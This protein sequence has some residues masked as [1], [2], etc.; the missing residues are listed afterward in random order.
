MRQARPVRETERAEL[1]EALLSC[2]VLLEVVGLF[3][4]WAVLTW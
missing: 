2:L 4:L 1:R 3:W